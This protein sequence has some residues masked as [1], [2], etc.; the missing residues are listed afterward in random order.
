I[1]EATLADKRVTG[2]GLPRFTLSLGNTIAYK[3][4]DLRIFF[5]SAFAFDILNVHEMY[6]GIPSATGNIMKRAYGKN[7]AIK[8]GN[9][10]L[11]DYFMEKG[12]Y[13]KLDVITLG[14]RIPVNTTW[15]SGMRA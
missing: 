8:T 10:V 9:N 14:Y 6:Y 1:E 7:A 3:N 12:D 11:T 4:F 13:L 15:V 5:R 2:N